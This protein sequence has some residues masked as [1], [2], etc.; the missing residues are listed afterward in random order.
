MAKNIL[1]KIVESKR[2]PVL[3]VGSGLSKRY[4]YNYPD[5]NE[6]LELSYAK[7]NA[8]SFQLQKYIDQFKRQ[9]LSQFEIN[10]H[11]AS[12]IED[13]FNAAFYDRKIKLG[14]VKNPAWVKRGISPF[15]MFLSRYFKKLNVYHSEATDR[16]MVQLRAL[17]N[18][19]SAVITTNYDLFLE[20]CIFS[21]DFKVFVHQ[22]ELFSSD[23]YNIAEIYKIHGSASDANSIIIT[24]KDYE[25]FKESRKLIIAK[26]LTLFAESPII[27]LG[28]SFTDENVQIIISEFLSC[29]TPAELKNI[30]E[31]FVFISYK[32]GVQSLQEVK[33]TIVTKKNVEIPI[34]EIQTD[35]F[36]KVYEILNQITPGIAPSRI[37]ETRKLVKT[38]VDQ[39]VANSDA[40]SV[41]VGI[42]DLSDANLASKPLAI[43]IGYRDNIL[44]KLGYGQL[45]DISIFEDILFNNKHF[46]AN[47]MCLSRFKSISPTRLLPVHKY[48]KQA[49]EDIHSNDKLV[50]YA[51]LHDTLEKLLPG[52]I[53][54][55]INS[56]P[57][58]S[59]YSALVTEMKNVAEIH[60]QA[61][62]VL[63]NIQSYSIKQIRTLCCEL[64]KLDSEAAFKSTHFKRCVMY[65]DLLENK[66][67]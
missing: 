29:L 59:D 51:E 13:E 37:R 23:S 66:S 27:F 40:D 50:R 31:H 41:I 49:T 30:D 26:M 7:V 24:A 3:F 2:M 5:W 67:N 53:K 25:Y 20:E 61:G 44:N 43:A 54:K 52:N 64:F 47:L 33:R 63:K 42:D 17:R 1:E 39:S 15:K 28:Y 36:Y 60:K 58:I 6:L 14:S 45:S 9:G 62:L 22:N 38:I 8:D 10:T 55:Q 19:I 34:T 57:V 56:V 11:L 21:S 32:K 65:I 18:K 46:D 48:I 16:E 35:N 4:L 12:A